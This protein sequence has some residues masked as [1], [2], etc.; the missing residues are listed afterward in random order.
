MVGL[1]KDK[2]KYFDSYN[3]YIDYFEKI[4]MLQDMEESKDISK[5]Q[6]EKIIDKLPIK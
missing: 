3:S 4:K 6:Y 1:D 5:E 2:L